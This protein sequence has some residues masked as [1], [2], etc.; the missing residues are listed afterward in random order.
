MTWTWTHNSRSL[1]NQR[2]SALIF[3]KLRSKSFLP[4]SRTSSKFNQLLLGQLPIFPKDVIKAHLKH[5]S[6][7]AN[8]GEGNN[9]TN[10]NKKSV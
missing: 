5:F 2:A 6:N 4:E 10:I 9:T 1:Y 3:G 8:T 7:F